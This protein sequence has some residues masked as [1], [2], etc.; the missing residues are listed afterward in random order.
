MTRPDTAVSGFTDPLTRN[1]AALTGPFGEPTDITGFDGLLT[2]IDRDRNG[3]PLTATQPNGRVEVATYDARGNRLSTEDE[4]LGGTWTYS[5]E[6]LFNQLASATNPFD[7][8][9][10]LS[11]DGNGNLTGLTSP[12]GR[13]H[14][15]T[16]DAGG[17]LDTW[18]DPHGLLVDLNL[19]CQKA[20]RSARY[21]YRPGTTHPD[22]HP[23]CLGCL[24]HHH[25]PLAAKRQLQL[26]RCRPPHQHRTARQ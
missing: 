8:T 7:Q 20:G 14:T 12:L 21:R 17:L 16:Y 26:R 13:T 10:T 9:T 22:L 19:R 5:Y 1:L 11:H 2:D 4:S 18:T 3:N 23:H 6:P 15:L 25:R 24:R